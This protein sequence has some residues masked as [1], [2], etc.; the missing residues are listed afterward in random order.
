LHFFFIFISSLVMVI[1]WGILV[2]F[3]TIFEGLWAIYLQTPPPPTPPPP[4]PPPRSRV[5]TELTLCVLSW[6]VTCL[7]MEAGSLSVPLPIFTSTGFLF[8]RWHHGRTF[9]GLSFCVLCFSAPEQLFR[10]EFLNSLKLCPN[11]HAKAAA[12][13]CCWVQ[14]HSTEYIHRAV[15]PPT[16]CPQILFHLAN[17]NLCP[18]L[19]VWKA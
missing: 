12:Q 10:L 6:L 11:T 5:L 3:F 15:P 7:S 4:A 1:I 18:V 9:D 8:C 14:L 2:I 17:L 19:S 16:I 13:T